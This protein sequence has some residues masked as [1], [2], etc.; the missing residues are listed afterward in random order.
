MKIY[1]SIC[2]FFLGNLIFAQ[3]PGPYF[4]SKNQ[5]VAIHTLQGTVQVQVYSP[6]ILRVSYTSDTHNDSSLVVVAKQIKTRVSVKDLGKEFRITTDS[7]LLF[8]DK[9]NL[10]IQYFAAKSIQPILK[11]NAEGN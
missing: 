6:T 5:R 11:A 8:I 9:Q 1:F 3:V 4:V 2:A 7:L 10:Q